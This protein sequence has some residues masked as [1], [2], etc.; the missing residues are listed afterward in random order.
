MKK[1][2]FKNDIYTEELRQKI[3][4]VY[5][6]LKPFN[7][8]KIEVFD[9][10]ITNIRLRAAFRI[11]YQSGRV[12]Y[13]MFEQGSKYKP[14]LVKK[15]PMATL[16]INYLMLQLKAAWQ[17]SLA[18]TYRLFQVEFHTTLSGD[19]L[20]TLCYHG[21]LNGLRKLA[22]IELSE[23]LRTSIIIRSKGQRFV[24]GKD[25]VTEILYVVH[26]FFK[27]RQPEGTFI[28]SNGLVNQKMINWVCKVFGKRSD[29][30]LELYCGNGNF[31]LPLATL[32]RKVLATEVN[33]ASLYAAAQNIKDNSIENAS[34]VRISAEELNEAL[35][36]NRIFHRLKEIQLKGYIFG[37]IFVNPPRS[38]MSFK[39]CELTRKFE[40]II[41]V[42]CNPVTLIENIKQLYDTH[43]IQKVAVFD[44]FPGTRHV[45]TGVLLIKR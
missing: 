43:N 12:H 1:Q 42:S 3:E 25:Y 15:F 24:A 31:T 40:R 38:G 32:A 41:Y 33:R 18:L 26:R 2:S 45:E 36:G 7:E 17:T 30:L 44:H 8:S 19:S 13:A 14:I 35:N 5:E 34:V 16:P 28:Q 4:E 11:W 23:K 20:I 39:V 21:P 9:S 10:P 6:L 27:Y 22:A 29:D 37:T